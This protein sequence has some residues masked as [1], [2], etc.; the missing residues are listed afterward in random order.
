MAPVVWTYL[1][2]RPSLVKSSIRFRRR[3]SDHR[4]VVAAKSQVCVPEAREWQCIG[5]GHRVTITSWWHWEFKRG[6]K[7]APKSTREATSKS[8]YS[9]VF[10]WTA[11]TERHR[12]FPSLSTACTDATFHWRISRGPSGPIRIQADQMRCEILASVFINNA[13]LH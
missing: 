4:A 2:H 6:R 3:M 12:C 8:P 5:S 7:N 9:P 10:F 13:D 11:S 1:K